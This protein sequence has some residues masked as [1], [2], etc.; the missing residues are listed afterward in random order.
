[1]LE[2]HNQ[3]IFK[4][5][6]GHD[7]A[8]CITTNGICKKDGSA[9]MGKGIA[10]TADD[11]FH[12]SGKLGEYL[13]KYGNRAFDMGFYSAFGQDEHHVLTFPTKM[14]W[15]NDS[16]IN[17]IVTSA[18]QIIRICDARGINKCYL[19]PV[20]CANGHLN[21]EALVQPVLSNILD[22]RFIVIVGYGI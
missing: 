13:T 2:I 4:I 6:H 21:Y 14:D 11:Y 19:P 10:K 17:L 22:D 20:G 18:E 7:E 8:I 3:D 15:R 9:V 5:A 12:I 1:M 16:N